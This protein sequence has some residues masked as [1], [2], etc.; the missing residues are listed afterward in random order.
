MRTK[1]HKR[2]G[3]VLVAVLVCVVDVYGT[4]FRTGTTPKRWAQRRSQPVVYL[5]LGDS[6]GVGIG[7]KRGGYVDRLFTRIE[8]AHPGSRL[9]NRCASGAATA[10]VLIRQMNQ[11]S[12]IKPTF[13][14]INI[15][16]NDLIQ[17]RSPEKFAHNYEEIILRLRKETVAPI[18]V[19]NIP[20]ISLAPA[21]PIYMRDSAR[22][23][24]VGFNSRIEEIAGRH[25][26]RLVDL[27][28]Q[29]RAFSPHREFFSQDGLHPS[30]V[31]YE[32]WTQLIW[33]ATKSLIN[34]RP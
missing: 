18:L 8:R 21:V 27:Y 34:S 32:F 5:A 11:T 23:H 15:G 16:A 26:L 12:H 30:D 31:G 10:D 17:G 14:T 4:A 28:N 22:R 3:W 7:A 2:F 13:I 9:V 29:S 1:D 19:M 20:D 6:T 24:I 33:P 25:D